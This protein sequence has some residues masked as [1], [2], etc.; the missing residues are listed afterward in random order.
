MDLH[1]NHK[2][3]KDTADKTPAIHKLYN[4][5]YAGKISLPDY[6]RAVKMLQGH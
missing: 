5:L 3:N 2:T 1:N 4:L 6:F